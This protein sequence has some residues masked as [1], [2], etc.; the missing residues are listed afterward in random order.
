[1][2]IGLELELP[3]IDVHTELPSAIGVYNM[4]EYEIVNSNGIANDPFKQLVLIGSEINTTP[5]STVQEALA[6][7]EELYSIVTTQ[8]N[9]MMVVHA[10][11]SVPDLYRDYSLL[12]KLIEYTYKHEQYIFD[13]VNRLPDPET[14]LMEYTLKLD[15]PQY[16]YIYPESYKERILSAKTWEDVR[17]AH[18]PMK[19]TRRLTHLVRRCGINIR[20]LWD[21]GTIEFRHFFGTDNLIE[22]ESILNWCTLYVENALGAQLP[23]ETLLSSRPWVFPKMHP[24]NEKLQ[25][26]WFYTNFKMHSRAEVKKRIQ[27]LLD[28]QAITKKGLS[29]LFT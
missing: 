9:H 26:G 7:V 6:Q 22:Y 8:T 18:Q 19:G 14:P 21:N 25:A 17:D 27:R 16:H 24:W 11:V 29:P 28:A 5:V 13:A 4:E 12:R 3:D 15:K 2:K 10:H 1:M 23:P 20:S